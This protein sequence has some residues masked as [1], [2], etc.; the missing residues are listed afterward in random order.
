MTSNARNDRAAARDT[1]RKMDDFVKIEK[2]DVDNVSVGM[3][4]DAK[5]ARAAARD[6]AAPLTVT[7][8][9]EKAILSMEGEKNMKV[10]VTFPN[11]DEAELTKT[12]MRVLFLLDRSASMSGN[13]EKLVSK[14][15]RSLGKHMSSSKVTFEVAFGCFGNNAHA[16]TGEDI[17]GYTPWFNPLTEEG[18]ATLLRVADAYSALG[19][20]TNISAALDLAKDMVVD[21]RLKKGIPSEES[22]HVI[23]LTDGNPSA[24]EQVPSLLRARVQKNFEHENVQFN[25]I[26]LGHAPDISVV[27]ALVEP[28]A[29]LFSYAASGDQI[30]ESMSTVIQPLCTSSVLF[31]LQIQDARV[32]ADD[33][34]GCRYSHF[35]LLTKY[36]NTAIVEID[37]RGKSAVGQHVSAAIGLADR[38]KTVLLMNFA[39]EPPEYQEMP[40][41]MADALLDKEHEKKM[42]EAA[43]AAIKAG[44]GFAGAAAA[45][46]DATQ[47]ARSA[48]I[49]GANSASVMRSARVST[50]YRSMAAATPSTAMAPHSDDEDGQPQY[51][52]MSGGQED[53]VLGENEAALGSAAAFSQAF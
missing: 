33:T 3:G 5:R 14:T 41:A 15:L 43:D 34:R 50:A 47:A 36:N 4:S 31:R 28:T 37:V 49:I 26:C 46:E 42:K 35:G 51:R 10:L 1:K 2:E 22:F 40:K 23:M 20:G 9:P 6:A 24:G 18:K 7:L 52:S 25:G 29:G 44:L 48:G 17:E 38:H 16:W 39:K 11:L 32:A 13:S 45:V 12:V 27:R 8:E 21:A 53:D 19:E 30:D